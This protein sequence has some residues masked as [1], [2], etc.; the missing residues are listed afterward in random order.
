MKPPRAVDERVRR[1]MSSNRG[2]DTGP[3]LRLRSALHRAGFRYRVNAKPAYG[4]RVKVDILF[5]R[6][7]VAVFVDGCFWHGC[8]KH[9]TIPKTNAAFWRMKIVGNCVRDEQVSEALIAAGWAVL[10]IWEHEPLDQAV[11]K[12]VAALR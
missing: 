3:E 10:R 11:S 1:S 8:Q 9:R 12:V 2:R 6:A 7:R 4:P 5:T